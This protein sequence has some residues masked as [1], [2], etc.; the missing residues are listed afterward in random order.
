VA[1]LGPGKFCHVTSALIAGSV[2]YIRYVWD[3]VSKRL[4]GILRDNVY[5][6]VID[7]RTDRN[8]LRELQGP[9][10][11]LDMSFCT[12]MVPGNTQKPSLLLRRS[13]VRYVGG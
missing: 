8:N 13:C 12:K 9:L 11:L 5:Q 3:G 6:C 7:Q 4:K 10:E 1:H 2:R